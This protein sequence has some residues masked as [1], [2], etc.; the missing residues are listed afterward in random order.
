MTSPLAPVVLTSSA[1]ASTAYYICSKFENEYKK[2]EKDED[3]DKD[4]DKDKEKDEDKDKD[5][6]KNE[7]KDKEKDEDKKKEKDE[8][9]EKGG[10]NTSLQK[11]ASKA[12]RGMLLAVEGLDKSGKST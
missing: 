5:K 2:K 3:K 7:D 4:K 11:N 8:E 6:E 10:T 1:L 9:K 12:K